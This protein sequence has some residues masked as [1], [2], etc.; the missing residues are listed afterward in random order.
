VDRHGR[1]YL[2]KWRPPTPHVRNHTRGLYGNTRK[3]TLLVSV[4]LGVATSTLPL[5]APAGTAVSI[6]EG[7]TT[8]NAAAMPLNFR[9]VAL[10]RLVPRILTAA[11]TA[12]E[13][14]CVPQTG[15]DRRRC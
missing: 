5:V 3:E 10:V 15:P 1:E 6:S 4:P 7:E 9:L 13:A 2:Y 12:P 11:P 14:G 8:V